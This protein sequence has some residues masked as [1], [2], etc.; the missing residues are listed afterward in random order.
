MALLVLGKSPVLKDPAPAKV[1]EELF[2]ESWTASP[3]W[4]IEL[5]PTLTILKLP[6]IAGIG[7]APLLMIL[8][9]MP[10]SAQWALYFSDTLSH[11]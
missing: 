6:T 8:Y 2:G 7:Q 11:S 1:F 5:G 4:T 3:I 9:C 10:A